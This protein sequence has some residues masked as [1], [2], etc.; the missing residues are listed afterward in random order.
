MDSLREREYRVVLDHLQETSAGLAADVREIIFRG[1]TPVTG[2]A[3]S[4]HMEDVGYLT[5]YFLLRSDQMVIRPF[6]PD[7]AHAFAEQIATRLR[8]CAENKAEFLEQVVDHSKG[9]PGNIVTLIKMALLPRYQ[10]RG[11]IKFSP[12]YIDF[13]LAWHATN[14]L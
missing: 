5:S 8:L 13:R 10:A 1:N 6:T 12:L 14:A 3:R 9:L 2:V 11:R 4:A 7:L